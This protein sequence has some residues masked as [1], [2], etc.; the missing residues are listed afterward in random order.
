MHILRIFL[1]FSLTNDTPNFIKY[2]YAVK[3]PKKAVGHCHASLSPKGYFDNCSTK[4][5]MFR[6]LTAILGS[7]KSAVAFKLAEQLYCHL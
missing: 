2:Y 6:I 5:D 4:I 7:G 3:A 1:H